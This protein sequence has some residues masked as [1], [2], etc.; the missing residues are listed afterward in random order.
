MQ[1]Y[2]IN[3]NSDKLI[4]FFS[5]WGCDEYEFEHLQ[6]DSD[7]LI[8]YDYQ[9]LNFDFDYSKYTVVNLIAFS[10]GVFAASVLDLGGIN[11]KIAISGN[12]YLF[13]ERLGLSGVIQEVLCN[14]TEANADDFAKNYLV[15]TDEEWEK[16]HHSRRTPDSCGTE[17]CKLKKL[18]EQNRSNIKDIYDAALF[19]E[20]DKI[21]DVSA[22]KDF[23]KSRINIIK[24]ARHNLFFRIN[25]YEELW[26]KC[27]SL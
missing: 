16:F 20:Y 23:Y 1:K 24:N 21:F 26:G 15:K 17:F 9:D 13:D 8:L 10:A 6:S 7:V 5:G 2:F 14:I 22:Q 27:A 25:K 19:G 4:L 11:K 12:P 3:N 18:Y